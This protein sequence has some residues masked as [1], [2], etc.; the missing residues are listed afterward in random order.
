MKQPK[1]R[2]IKRIQERLKEHENLKKT[3]NTICNKLMEDKALLKKYYIKECKLNDEKTAMSF[4]VIDN[5]YSLEY[6]IQPDKERPN[7]IGMINLFKIKNDIDIVIGKK[8]KSLSILDILFNEQGLYF[9]EGLDEIE[10]RFMP[11]KLVFK[12]MDSIC[13]DQGYYTSTNQTIGPPV[14]IKETRGYN[15][16]N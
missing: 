5:I 7:L 1:D 15:M 14:V 16:E 6:S 13:I 8:K 2:E 9:D 3:F 11:I 10:S 12:I 4:T